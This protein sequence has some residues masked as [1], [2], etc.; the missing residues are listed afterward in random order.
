MR[1]SWDKDDPTTMTSQPR[2]FVMAKYSEPEPELLS[3]WRE[4]GFNV[5]YLP[6]LGN[7]KQFERQVHKLGN[8]LSLSEKF[9]VVG[10]GLAI[11]LRPRF[12]P[13]FS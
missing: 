8:P 2:L 12:P 10:Q 1:F 5:T 7:T 6:Y 4:E 11:S 3:P 13:A 9:A